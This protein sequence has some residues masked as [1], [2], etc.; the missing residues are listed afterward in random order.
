MEELKL[1]VNAH[2][3]DTDT[4]WELGGREALNIKVIRMLFKLI[5][6]IYFFVC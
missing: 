1:F 6:D 2:V 4:Y 3:T 5:P